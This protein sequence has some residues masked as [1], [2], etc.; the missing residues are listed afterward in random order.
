MTD[1][2][3]NRLLAIKAELGKTTSTPGWR[4]VQ[5]LANNVVQKFV[6][7]ALDEED[8]EKGESKRLKAKALQAGFSDLFSTIEAAKAFD[9][10]SSD[11][12]G[13]GNLEFE[14]P[15]TGD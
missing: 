7:E 5:K 6:Q 15:E 13:L 4:M 1:P 12:T 9:P 11:D 2:E 3:T 8:R 14:I 10:Q